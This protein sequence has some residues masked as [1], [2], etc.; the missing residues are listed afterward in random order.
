MRVFIFNWFFDFSNNY[1]YQEYMGLKQKIE[2]AARSALKNQEPELLS[3]LRMLLAAMHNREIEKRT[4]LVKGGVVEDL[5]KSSELND[6][7][8]IE[9]IR[10]ESKKRREAVVEYEKAGRQESAEKETRELKIL[11]KYLPVELSDEEIE[12]IAQETIGQRGDITQKD[13]GRL[14]GEVMKRVK[15]QASGDRVGK[16]L[17]NK[18]GL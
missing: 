10:S 18:I 4:R 6:G 13:F 9:V 15:G 7:E 17:K 3:T 11:E 1:C 2:D 12:K 16:I 14:M 5:E 8:V